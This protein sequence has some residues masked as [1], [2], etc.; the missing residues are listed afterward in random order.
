VKDWVTDFV[1]TGGDHRPLP[2]R[3]TG[4]AGDA[5]DIV[6]SYR[7]GTPAATVL[8]D[9]EIHEPEK[10]RLRAEVLDASG[11]LQ[12][13]EPVASVRGQLHG[14]EWFAFEFL[15]PARGFGPGAAEPFWKSP[16][17]T[18]EIRQMLA[19]RALQGEKASKQFLWGHTG[20]PDEPGKYRFAIRLYPT[21][22]PRVSRETNPQM[23]PPIDLV[24]YPLVVTPRDGE[25]PRIRSS[26][27]NAD[28][29]DTL[30]APY[31][32]DRPPAG[33]GAGRGRAPG[34][35]R[36]RLGDGTL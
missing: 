19:D 18:K 22:D 32:R 8:A 33:I 14:F 36:S 4:K 26:M 30:G 15:D 3:L 11:T 20:L 24:S 10:W 9:R 29:L 23:G 31:R 7:P 6:V 27:Y 28:S 25:R 17:T 16:E 1:V 12:A 2:Q 34:P 13:A 5:I 21:A 35:R